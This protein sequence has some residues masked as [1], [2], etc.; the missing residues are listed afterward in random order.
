MVVVLMVVF[1]HQTK[2]Q[3]VTGSVAELECTCTLLCMRCPPCVCACVCAPACVFVRVS[4]CVLPVF[5]SVRVVR[6]VHTRTCTHAHTQQSHAH[7][8]AHTHTH[9]THIHTHARTHMHSAELPLTV[10]Q[11]HSLTSLHRQP[12]RFQTSRA[13][14]GESVLAVSDRAWW[15]RC[16]G[17]PL[18]LSLSLLPLQRVCVCVCVCTGVSVTSVCVCACVCVSE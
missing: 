5:A 18:S 10:A 2:N 3:R 11:T 6:F 15:L 7:A 8:R 17:V 4:L 13:S 1:V 12:V 16:D 9:H 14:L